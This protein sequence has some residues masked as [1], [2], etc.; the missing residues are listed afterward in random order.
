MIQIGEQKKLI[1]P[2]FLYKGVI[3]FQN[4]LV[5]VK[6][7]RKNDDEITYVVEYIDREGNPILVEGI[8]ESELA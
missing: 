4:S 1:K 2:T 6:D 5:I 8:K 7:I 3:I